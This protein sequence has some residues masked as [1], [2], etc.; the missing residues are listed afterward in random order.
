MGIWSE[1]S[2]F[3]SINLYFP[4]SSFCNCTAN[5]SV[6]CLPKQNSVRFFFGLDGVLANFTTHAAMYLDNLKLPYPE[7]GIFEESM[8]KKHFV[9]EVLF[10]VCSGSQFWE[11]IPPYPWAWNFFSRAYELS[12]GDIYFGSRAHKE[13]SASWD[14]KAAWVHK[15]FGQ[16]GVDRLVLSLHAR[17]L[18]MACN[19]KM[20]VLVAA[21]LE[22]VKM[23]NEM[24]G[25]ALYFPELDI[26]WAGC[27]IEISHRLNAMD[28]IVSNLKST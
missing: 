27:A 8:L 5:T 25:S 15:H 23:W 17:N 26:R 18:C 9:P 11:G 7:N 10:D 14:G 19:G 20:D 28:E 24:G 4:S 3:S 13:D 2:S 16:Y 1:G 21:D 6:Q 12:H 22:N